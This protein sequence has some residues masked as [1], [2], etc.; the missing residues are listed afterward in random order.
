M[1]AFFAFD[2]ALVRGAKRS[3]LDLLRWAVFIVY[4][5]FGLLK[6]FGLSPA[7]PL[8]HALLDR[9]MPFFPLEGFLVAWGAFEVLIGLAFLLKGWERLAI[10]LVILHLLIVCSPLL[11]LPDRTWQAFLVP[12]MEGQYILKNVFLA[13]MMVVLGAHL[14]PMETA[15]H[16]RRSA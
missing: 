13:V 2:R 11:L 12:T 10:A 5:W 1:H 9:T 14:R 4:V 8:V 16:S 7:S 6:M 3:G 15:S